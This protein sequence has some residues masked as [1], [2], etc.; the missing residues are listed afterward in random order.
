MQK[1]AENACDKDRVPTTAIRQAFLS[2]RNV[3]L[4]R[5]PIEGKTSFISLTI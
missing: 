3:L 2:A 1:L 5:F 4:L